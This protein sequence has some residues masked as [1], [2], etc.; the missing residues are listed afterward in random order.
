[1]SGH[2]QAWK[3][4]VLLLVVVGCFWDCP[5]G[6][7]EE[8]AHPTL[9]EFKE[10]VGRADLILRGTVVEVVDDRAWEEGVSGQQILKVRVDKLYKGVFPKQQIIVNNFYGDPGAARKPGDDLILLPKRLC[11]LPSEPNPFGQDLLFSSPCLY[12]VRDGNVVSSTGMADDL[13]AYGCVEKF[14]TLIEKTVTRSRRKRQWLQHEEFVP[15]KVLFLDD[16]SDGSMSG[17]TLLK[18]AR[19]WTEQ[20]EGLLGFLG[21]VWMSEGLNWK[22]KYPIERQGTTGQ[23]V[24]GRQRN[25]TGERNG[26]AI[27]IGV[28]NGRMR[29]RSSFIHQHVTALAGNPNWSDYQI[30]VDM[31]SR[32]DKH[33]D[34]PELIAEGDYKTFGVF[35]RV[36][37]PNL[38]NTKGEHC[39]IGV[40]F[41]NYSNLYAT[42][43]I[44][45]H[46]T[47]QIRLKTAD[48]DS[49][50]DG[51]T[52]ER[53]TKILD[54]ETY[55]IPKD[56]AIHVTAKFMGRRVEG[57]IDGKKYVDGVIPES[58]W[59]Q[60]QNGRIGVWV[61][62]TFA[63]FD[64]VKVT[65][66]VRK[67]ADR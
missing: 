39:E 11:A 4:A 36:T 5:S 47:I 48:A 24:R 58:N 35:G 9:E 26:T 29:L 46:E 19:P 62:T 60:F 16:F 34:T 66:L 59:S 17:W 25:L 64:N 20:E 8:L 6:R 30:D 56:R 38:P 55:D 53:K 32:N 7:S 31:F 54:Y 49:G 67:N 28:E 40:E 12:H 22:N 65:E 44:V 1:M 50:R 21:E 27:Q 23:L 10:E 15:G 51:A 37:V 63:E 3:V 61:F 57:W 18:G 45:T 2:E 52:I 43:S 13:A 14:L 33:I 41:G 42:W